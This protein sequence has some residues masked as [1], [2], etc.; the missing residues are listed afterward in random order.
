MEV[1]ITLKG[2]YNGEKK[3]KILNYMAEFSK[4]HL[5]KIVKYIENLVREKNRK[6]IFGFLIYFRQSLILQIFLTN[7]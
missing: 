1:F 4:I 7:F 5:S 2:K 6:I 3:G